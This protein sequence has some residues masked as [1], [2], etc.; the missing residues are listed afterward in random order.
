MISSGIKPAPFR[1]ESQRLNQLRHTF[2]HPWLRLVS[3]CL[4]QLRHTLFTLDSRLYRSASTNC[5]T[6]LYTLDSG[7]YRSAST[8][9]ATLCT[10][11]TPACIAVPQTT[12][13]HFVHPCL[14]LVSRCL[15]QL[16]RTLCTPASGLYRGASTN[17][18][19]L[20]TPQTRHT[21]DNYC[22]S[23]RY[24]SSGNKDTGRTLIIWG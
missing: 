20:C 9:C 10:P 14:R 5:V 23:V 12:S 24:T 21:I 3:Q 15:K 16:R 7:L 19:T 13:P 22:R 6:L 1:F 8:N 18:A 2:V 11:Q 4:N 17:C